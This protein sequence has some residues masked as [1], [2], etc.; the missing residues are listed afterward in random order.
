MVRSKAPSSHFFF[1]ASHFDLQSANELL[2]S[3]SELLGVS[4]LPPATQN[5]VLQANREM[6]ISSWIEEQSLRCIFL[7]AQQ[8]PVFLR[9]GR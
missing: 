6:V 4:A 9:H 1:E 7:E 5:K 3:R 2:R 8:F